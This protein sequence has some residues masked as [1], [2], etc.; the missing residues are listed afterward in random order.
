ME[1]C[2]NCRQS[3]SIILNEKNTLIRRI[4]ASVLLS[5]ADSIF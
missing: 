3:L 5:P 4:L 1:T 2:L